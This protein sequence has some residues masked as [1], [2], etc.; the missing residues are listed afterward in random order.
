MVSRIRSEDHRSACGAYQ[1]PRDLDYL[2]VQAR[3]IFAALPQQ[4]DYSVAWSSKT[5]ANELRIQ[6]VGRSL[7]KQILPKVVR[8]RIRNIMMGHRSCFNNEK[9]FQPV[10]FK[11]AAVS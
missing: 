1:H 8:R 4:S 2:L 11:G 10:D 5:F 7:A 9:A 6:R 3:P